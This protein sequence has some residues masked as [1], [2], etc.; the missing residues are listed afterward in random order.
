MKSLKLSN[1]YFLFVSYFCF[2]TFFNAN[3]Q[4]VSSENHA[5]II[6]SPNPSD[7]ASKKVVYTCIC[8]NY[9]ELCSQTYIPIGWDYICF[10]DNQELIEHG[11]ALWTIRPLIY[12]ERDKTRNSRW[13]KIFP[14]I[15]LSEYDISFYI[16]ANTNIK[17]SNIFDYIEKE[18]LVNDSETLAINKHAE[19]NCIYKEASVCRS[20][21]LDLPDVIDHQMSIFRMYNYPQ[22]NGLV[23]SSMIFRR[24]HDQNVKKVMEDWWFW[25]S[26]GSKRDQLSF[27]FVIWLHQFN[28]HLFKQQFSHN[29]AYVDCFPHIGK[30]D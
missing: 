5:N 10:T 9:D 23:D 14:H 29:S 21:S 27:N 8:G 24:H 7:F 30:R 6:F 28:V 19:R 4:E 20:W 1:M 13:H 22:S 25:V 17:N 16:D 3:S 26:T 11:H 15:I 12:T 2:C 18:L